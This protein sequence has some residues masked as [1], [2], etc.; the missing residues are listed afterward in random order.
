MAR[1]DSKGRFVSSSRRH[2]HR[3]RRNPA[4]AALVPLAGKVGAAKALAGIGRVARV[5][6]VR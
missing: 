6:V 3:R 5:I 1:R 4:A 2:H